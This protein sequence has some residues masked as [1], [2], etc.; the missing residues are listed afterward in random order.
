MTEPP[1]PLAHRLLTPVETV[2]PAALAARWFHQH[3]DVAIAG[4]ASLAADLALPVR[5]RG[6]WGQELMRAASPEALADRPCPWDPPCALDALFREQGR[7]TPRLALPRPYVFSVCT[8]ESKTELNIR[9]SLF[10]FATDW[11]DAA[12]E[13]LTAALRGGDPLRIGRTSSNPGDVRLPPIHRSIR[14]VESCPIPADSG[15]VVL[16]FRTPL[17]LRSGG[18]TY[19]PTARPLVTSLG[20]R[21]SG[22]ARWLDCRLETDWPALAAHAETLVCNAEAMTEAV[23]QRRSGRQDGRLIPVHGWCGRLILQGD[24][25]PVLPLLVLGATC[26]AGSHAAHGL[27][28]YELE[29]PG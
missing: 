17:A 12:A 28:A 25:A 9:L 10:G 13:A 27:G 11:T 29:I 15:L 8:S 1:S 5:V 19:R 24:L 4:A 16:N 26:H 22:L 21:L 18:D 23:W 14:T 20:N 2:D 6:A 3:I 7:L